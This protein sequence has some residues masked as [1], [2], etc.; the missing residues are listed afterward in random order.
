MAF[1]PLDWE[2]YFEN[3]EIYSPH[4]TDQ[5]KEDGKTTFLKKC[6][7][8]DQTLSRGPTSKYLTLWGYYRKN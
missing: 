1:L 3:V 5:K 2:N 6:F 8:F 7:L 4:F